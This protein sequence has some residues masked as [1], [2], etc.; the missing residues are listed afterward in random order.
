[1]NENAI[2][3]AWIGLRKPE[4]PCKGNTDGATLA[5]HRKDWTWQD[6]AEYTYPVW[7][8]WDEFEPGGDEL[9]ARLSLAKG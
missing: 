8:N 3:D 9:C 6:G 4:D 2:N 7:H 5:Y 1:M